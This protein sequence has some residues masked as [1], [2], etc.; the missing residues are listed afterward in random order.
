MHEANQIIDGFFIIRQE[1]ASKDIIL[2]H[3]GQEGKRIKAE[4]M[5]SLDELRQLLIRERAQY[6]YGGDAE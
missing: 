2:K 1:T 3:N 4:T 6:F 5:K